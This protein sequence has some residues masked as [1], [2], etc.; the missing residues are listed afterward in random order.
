M[1]NFFSGWYLLYTR[2]RHEKKVATQLCN[3]KLEYF[4]PLTQQ[5]QSWKLRKRSLL[6]PLFPSYIFVKLTCFQDYFISMDADGV[7]NYVRFNKQPAVVKESV[8][9]QLRL[10]VESGHDICV[11]N[12]EFKRGETVLIKEGALGGL[13]SE[14]VQYQ[15]KNKI[16]VR[17]QLLSRSVLVDLPV[18][19]VT[20]SPQYH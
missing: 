2:P 20:A 9:N 16:L 3:R 10:V 13:V 11:S 14:V 19:S 5:L 15:G 7:S 4:L 6:V 1:G 17:V 8:I 18:H 12:E